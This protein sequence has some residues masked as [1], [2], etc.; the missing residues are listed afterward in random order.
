M[1][2]ISD[3]HELYTLKAFEYYQTRK[4]VSGFDAIKRAD[5]VFLPMPAYMAALPPAP[6][7][8][9]EAA[10]R[11]MERRSPNYHP[12]PAYRAYKTR[13]RF[14]DFTGNTLR[15]LVGLATKNEPTIE[16]P[17]GLEYMLEDSATVDGG[18]LHDLFKQTLR[19]LLITGRFSLLPDIDPQTG[20]ILFATYPAET[21]INWRT[22]RGSGRRELEYAVLEELHDEGT[23]EEE[24]TYLELYLDG[25][26]FTVQLYENGAAIGEPIQPAYMGQ[27]LEFLPLVV[28][29]S[30]DFDIEPDVV[31]LGGLADTAVHVYQKDADLSHSQYLSANPTLHYFGID[32]DEAPRVIGPGIAV[33]INNPEARAEYVEISGGGHESIQ[34]AIDRLFEQALAQGADLLSLRKGGVESGEALKIRQEASGAT[35]KTVVEQ[36]G[37]GIERALKIAAIWQGLDPELVVF[38]PVTEFAEVSMTAQEQTA[39]LQSWMNRA[40]SYETYF[41]TIKAAGVIDTENT[42]E[43]EQAK[44]DTEAPA[45]VAPTGQPGQ[46]A[47]QPGQPGQGEEGADDGAGERP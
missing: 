8:S 42:A 6:S 11:E 33:A 20:E 46:G 7:F 12:N 25:G 34:G 44:I 37:R 28:I 38:D 29:G 22:T 30:T 47:G 36:A 1:A 19:E 4:A 45:L 2:S 35:L 27:T 21:L 5:T 43:E 13:A 10:I 24:R 15:G 9:Q 23:P 17:P 14:P 39:L 18:N 32:E 16:L 31:P 3:R 26:T 41:D 40:I